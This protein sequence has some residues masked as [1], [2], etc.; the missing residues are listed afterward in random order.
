MLP[1][2]RTSSWRHST[3][4]ALGRQACMRSTGCLLNV[5]ASNT[6][7]LRPTWCIGSS[8]QEA[9]R[10]RLVPA[11]APSWNDC[12]LSKNTGAGPAD[13]ACARRPVPRCFP[14][15]TAG[16]ALDCVAAEPACMRSSQQVRMTT[17]RVRALAGCRTALTTQRY[18][19]ARACMR[20]LD[21]GEAGIAAGDVLLIARRR[22]C[23]RAHGVNVTHA[24]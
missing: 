13:S 8:T 7:L 2:A 10:V 1:V 16:P 21:V 19:N 24:G 23:A 5:V 3:R 22:I 20:R 9:L 4:W 18:T 17:M 11:P 12:W 14:R 15:T 6:A